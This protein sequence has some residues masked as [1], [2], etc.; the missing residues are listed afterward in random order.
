MEI[1][2]NFKDEVG[3]ISP[4]GS[5]D[6][7]TAPK[8]AQFIS[9]QIAEGHVKL[10]ADLSKLDYTSS[11]GLRALLGAVKEARNFN[12]DMYLASV[13]PS[14]EKVLKLSG[15]TRI[16]KVFPDVETAVNSFPD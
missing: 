1:T 2:I 9:D 5:M 8:L 3:I 14:V 16:L 11:A 6:A 15:F 7:L 10:V 13:Q 4:T 12:G